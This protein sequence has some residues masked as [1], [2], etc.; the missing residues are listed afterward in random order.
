MACAVT[1]AQAISF[2]EIFL[3]TSMRKDRDPSFD[4]FRGLA[5]IA[6]ITNHALYIGDSLYNPKLLYFFQLLLFAVPVFFFISGYWS[7]KSPIESLA[8]YR[9]F[10]GKRFQRVLIPY[11]FWSVILLGYLA[12]K[13]HNIS[14]Y[15][16]IYLLLSGGIWTGY[17]F[18]VVLAQLYVITPVL[19]Y[20]NRRLNKYGLILVV[21]FYI[22]TLLV[23]YLSLVF[24]VIWTLPHTRLFYSWIIYYE[25][26]LFVGTHNSDV[27]ATRKRRFF[28]LFGVLAFCLVSAVEAGVILSKYNNLSFAMFPMKY[29]SFLYSVCVILG[30]LSVKEYF[31]RLPGLLSTIGHY[32]FGI[33]FIHVII[34]GLVIRCIQ[35]FSVIYSFQPLYH[36]MLVVITLSLC[37]IL[38]ITARKL[39]PEFICTKILGF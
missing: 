17:Y 10:L 26:G 35:K 2:S 18:I 7:S 36:L 5:I 22:I 28:L 24:K 19:Q 9:N 32:S 15:K 30:F 13:Y 6:V 31:G 27:F 16:M 20:I 33:Y 8:D 38:I 29:S 4:A 11:L 3:L 37:L 1:C 12:I 21:V 14:G 39:L 34:L 23:L 25:I